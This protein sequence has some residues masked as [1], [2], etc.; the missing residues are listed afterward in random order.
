MHFTSGINRPPYEANSGFL[1]VTSGCSHASC[2]FCSYFKDT[3]FKKSPIEEI[4]ADIREIPEYFGAPERIFLQGADGFA[5]DYD[6]LMKTAELIHRY[7][8][9]VKTIGGYARI[10]NFRNKSVEQ[11]RNMKAAGFAEPYIGVE[12]GDDAIL[13]M[14]NKGY[15]AAFARAQMEK[16]TEAGMSFIANFL[17]GL[18]GVG[19]GLSHARKTAEIYEGMDI[20]MIE[21]SSLT[22]VPKTILYRRRER[23]EFAEAGEHERL[24]EM[25]EFI[26][27]LKNKTVFLSDHIS[28]LFRAR[29]NLPEDKESL[30]EGI[31][32]VMNNLPEE[33]MKTHRRMAA[34]YF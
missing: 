2:A 10:D 17:N 25:Q 15:D 4:E 27:C 3:R 7:V 1:Q 32:K 12:S 24:E 18:G 28:V 31:Q 13:K 23:G 19:Y 9:S 26:R 21:V 29:A 22:L 5:A 33:R 16:L 8:P 11:L 30:I 6:V 20:S 34:N 14:V